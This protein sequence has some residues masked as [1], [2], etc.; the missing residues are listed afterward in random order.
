MEP[1]WSSILSSH[2]FVPSSKHPFHATRSTNNDSAILSFP[3]ML[4]HLFWTRMLLPWKVARTSFA[5]A[6]ALTVGQ[7]PFWTSAQI[8]ANFQQAEE[9]KERMIVRKDNWPT[10]FDELSCRQNVFRPRKRSRPL[11]SSPSCQ[12]E[13]LKHLFGSVKRNLDT[14]KTDKLFCFPLVLVIQF[15]TLYLRTPA[16]HTVY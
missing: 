13:D 5:L 8:L 7:E 11:Q 10:G 15:E 6:K 16:R 14:R 3:F 9:S 1:H 4:V 12:K 2:H